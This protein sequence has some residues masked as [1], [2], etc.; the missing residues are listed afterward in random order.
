[1]LAECRCGE[2]RPHALLAFDA[3]LLT[4]HRAY[5]VCWIKLTLSEFSACFFVV[6]VVGNLP[7]PLAPR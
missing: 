4:A 5:A 3:M 2:N 6:V 7:P 1:M